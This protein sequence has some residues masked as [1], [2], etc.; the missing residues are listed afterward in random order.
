MWASIT[1]QFCIYSTKAA[2]YDTITNECG[3]VPVKLYFQKLAVG[4]ICPMGHS[5]VTTTLEEWLSHLYQLPLPITPARNLFLTSNTPPQLFANIL[6]VLQINFLNNSNPSTPLHFLHYSFCPLHYIR[7]LTCL[8]TSTVSPLPQMLCAPQQSDLKMEIETCHFI[9]L[10]TMTKFLNT[11]SHTLHGL[12][13]TCPS[14]LI[15][16]CISLSHPSP[17]SSNLWAQTFTHTF[18]TS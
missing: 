13:F 18:S 4:K 15:S 17:S 2:I 10:M 11:A 5:L 12:T 16:L 8:L 9:I 7:P 6:S 14:I 1:T 3:C